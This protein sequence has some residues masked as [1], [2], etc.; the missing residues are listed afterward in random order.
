MLSIITPV[1]NS[2]KYLAR[3]IESVLSQKDFT[4]FEFICVDDGS[5]DKSRQILDTYGNDSRLIILEQEN[6]GA[7]TARNNAINIAKGDYIMFL[8]SDDII[9]SGQ[10]VKKAYDYASKKD[11]FN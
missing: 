1:Y 8:D 2:E 11:F 5:K 4:D 10:N 7:G 3:C 6:S 9:S